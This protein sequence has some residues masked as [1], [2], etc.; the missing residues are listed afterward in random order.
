MK[1]RRPSTVFP[2]SRFDDEF[3]CFCCDEWRPFWFFNHCSQFKLECPDD[4][5]WVRDEMGQIWA[6]KSC[7]TRSNV[8]T[9][10]SKNPELFPVFLNNG[11]ELD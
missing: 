1:S 8:Y 7:F 2:D 5:D 3:Q 6:C 9:S 11:A 4:I 10:A